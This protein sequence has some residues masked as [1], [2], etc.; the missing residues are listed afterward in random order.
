VGAFNLSVL[1]MRE[2]SDAVKLGATQTEVQ[3]EHRV[4]EDFSAIASQNF[5]RPVPAAQPM[6]AF[7][8][9]RGVGKLK[10]K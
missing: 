10:G 4:Q 8:D 1:E 3:G 7:R 2:R 5:K 9:T 6:D